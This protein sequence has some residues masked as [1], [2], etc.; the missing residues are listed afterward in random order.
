LLALSAATLFAMPAVAREPGKPISQQDVSAVDVAATPANDLNLRKEEIPPL[1]IAAE[2]HPYSLS[3]LGNCRR[4][5]A[6]VG[7]LDAVLGDDVDFPQADDRRIRPGRVAQSVVGS[8]IPFRGLIR[9]ISGASEHDRQLQT[10]ILAGVARRSF[11]KGTGQ[12]RGCRYPARAATANAIALYLATTEQSSAKVEAR[13]QD[14][15]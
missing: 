6:A 1:L 9:E 4:L 13:T 10:A 5:T 12:A 8:F 7:G 14:R 3:G 11:L 15:Q 2:Q